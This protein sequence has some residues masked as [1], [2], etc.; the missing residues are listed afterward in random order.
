MKLEI[1]GAASAV[2][3]GFFAMAG[4]W[5]TANGSS[6]SILV[7]AL[8]GAA[9]AVLELEPF[10]LKRA[11]ML[12]L[13]NG[14]VGT[15]GGPLLLLMVGLEPKSLPSAALVLVPFLL[16]W[17]AHTALSQLRTVAISLAAKRLGGAGQ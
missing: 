6:W 15:F 13:F 5:L 8:I 17:A 11:I 10:T 7:V 9:I 1:F 14:L 4:T 12:F 3:A 2:S 16:G